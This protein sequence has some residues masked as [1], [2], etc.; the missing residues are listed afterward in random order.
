MEKRL[1]IAIG[2]SVLVMM[3]FQKVMPP[4]QQIQT[5]TIY[6]NDM[7]PVDSQEVEE[8]RNILTIK[9]ELFEEQ[10]DK[11]SIIF[12]N[13]NGAIKSIKLKEYDFVIFN[14]EKPSQYLFNTVDLQPY[15]KINQSPFSVQQEKGK[16][17]FSYHS[18]ESQYI[19][20]KEYKFTED[21]YD[22]GLSIITENGSDVTGAYKYEVTTSPVISEVSGVK[23][24]KFIET[25]FQVN[26]VLV[27]KKNIKKAKEYI[28]GIIGWTAVKNRYFIIAVQPPKTAD[29]ITIAKT[30]NN[31]MIETVILEPQIIAPGQSAQNEFMLVVAPLKKEVLGQYNIGLE[32]AINYGF[33][34]GISSLLL[35][36][37]AFIFKIVHNW[38]VAIIVVTIIINAALLPL[39]KKSMSSMYKMQELQPHM[40]RLRQLHKDNPQKLNK[41]M[42]ELYKEYNVNPFGGCLPML[43]QFPIFIAF[44]QALMRSTELKNA[45]F[46]WIKDLS[47]PDAL[48]TFSQKIPILG[49]SF[50]LLPI[51]TLILMIVQQKV[52]TAGQKNISPEM[53]QQQKM[54]ALIFPL[55][56]GV[57]LYNFSSGLVLYWLTNSVLMTTEQYFIKKK[58]QK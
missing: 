9:E 57:I 49:Q 6:N 32:K 7:Q 34:G 38:G 33:F 43:L 37:L 8:K 3:A 13:V 24:Q 10:T 4:T 48:F 53:A 41:E 52:T 26:G 46:L 16:I 25:N 27:T 18:L 50:N 1:I 21:S 5:E 19:I 22:I 30:D 56:F 17:T 20:K 12:S 47:G 35:S 36:L 39:T 51:I 42:M 45:S 28:K 14:E 15:A 31:E 2:L 44:Y 58:L 55:F 40:E 54:M 23:G 29:Q 11:L